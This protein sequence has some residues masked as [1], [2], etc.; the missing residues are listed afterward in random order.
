MIRKKY[1]ACLFALGLT[2]S[3]MAQNLEQAKKLFLEG[4]FEKAKP[5]FQ[6]LVKKAPSN[7]NYNYWYGACCYETGE[8]VEAQ[9]YL[10]KSAARKVIDAVSYTHLDYERENGQISVPHIAEKN[11]IK[12]AVIGSGP[13]GPE[14]MTAILIPFF[15]AMC[16]TDI[17]PFSRS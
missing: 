5:V 12:I 15:S 7:A 10:E 13:A 8:K 1:I 4:E 3:M 6:S 16:G 11:G 9:P 17:C 14:P 2:S